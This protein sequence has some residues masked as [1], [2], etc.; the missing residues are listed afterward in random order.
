MSKKEAISKIK[1]IIKEYGTFTCAD[2]EATSSPVINSLGKDT[3]QLAE[4][5]YEHKIEAVLYVHEQETDTD[6]I[7]YEELK[8][9]T[10]LEILSLAET[11]KEKNKD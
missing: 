6:F 10:L 7:P 3:H 1:E 8:N 9:F 5:F 4:R 2:V 11:W